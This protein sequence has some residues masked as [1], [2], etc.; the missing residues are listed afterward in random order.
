MNWSNFTPAST[1]ITHVEEPLDSSD[2][3]WSKISQEST[4]SWYTNMI[5]PDI[6]AGR[7]AIDLDDSSS[8]DN[9]NDNNDQ[10][11][12]D[13]DEEMKMNMKK[14]PMTKQLKMPQHWKAIPK[15]KGNKPDF[16]P[17]TT[18]VRYKANSNVTECKQEV[19][20]K[21]QA[22]ASTHSQTRNG[23]EW[24]CNKHI[25]HSPTIQQCTATLKHQRLTKRQ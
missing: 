15:H 20:D 5:L 9:D 21:R 16:K 6:D 11:K 3:D 18:T 25:I 17:S 10:N 7:N 13:K 24:M 1:T 19:N 12:T 14:K 8:D 23:K 22:K 4:N 2:D